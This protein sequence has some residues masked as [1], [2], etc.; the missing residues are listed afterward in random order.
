V[1]SC[2]AMTNRRSTFDA[3]VAVVAQPDGVPLP[4]DV[5]LDELVALAA[6]HRVSGYLVRAL[7]ASDRPLPAVLAAEHGGVVASHL[8]SLRSLAVVAGALDAAGIDWVVV[9]G[10]VLATMWHRDPGS[11][12]YDDLDLLV[13]PRGLGDALAALEGA[14][15]SHRNA[16]WKGF[17][18]VGVGEVPLDDGTTVVDLHWHL[19]GLSRHRRAFEIRTHELLGRAVRIE[20]GAVQAQTLDDLDTLA[21]LCVHDAFAGARQLVQLK[22]VHLVASAVRRDEAAERLRSLGI[23]NL[24]AVVLDRAERL[25]GTVGEGSF[26]EAVATDRA[27]LTANRRVD[28]A[29]AAPGRGWTPF[30]GALVGAGRST[31]RETFGAIA[32][33]LW[34]A[35]STRLHLRNVVSEGGPLDWDHEAGGEVER[36]RFLDDVAQGRY[37]W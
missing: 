8:R 26:A 9:K 24:A 29:W 20:L 22:D 14:A 31:R 30:P 4:A 12:A 2:D 15:F 33:Q 3:L 32:N 6:S 11:R 35:T 17:R 34:H 36:E 21:H 13:D 7:R 10:P 25:F 37:G 1:P 18:S 16:N 28:R 23:E 19:I 27:W 5:D